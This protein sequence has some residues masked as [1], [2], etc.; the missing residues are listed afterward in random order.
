MKKLSKREFRSYVSDYKNAE[1]KDSWVAIAE[2]LQNAYNQMTESDW[3]LF[4]NTISVDE[5]QADNLTNALD[6]YH[7][8]IMQIKSES[9]NHEYFQECHVE[10]ELLRSGIVY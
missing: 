7:M 2:E 5:D 3:K 1:K 10:S 6:I 9:K 4:L 8:R